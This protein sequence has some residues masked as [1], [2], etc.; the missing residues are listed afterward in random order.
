MAAQPLK[1]P[2]SHPV[3]QAI[4]V[5]ALLF[6][7][8]RCRPSIDLPALRYVGLMNAARTLMRE[9]TGPDRLVRSYVTIDTVSQ[10]K[11]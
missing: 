4:S 8:R 5:P 3:R 9:T 10:N 2:Y 1:P 7:C 6:Y 11:E